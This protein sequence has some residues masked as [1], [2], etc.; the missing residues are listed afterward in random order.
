MINTTVRN[1]DFSLQ[2]LNKTR[3]SEMM[4]CFNLKSGKTTILPFSKQLPQLL[5]LLPNLNSRD[6]MKL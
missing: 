1:I 4:M 6:T 3:I 2:M 5:M